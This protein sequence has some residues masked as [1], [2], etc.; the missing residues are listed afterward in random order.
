MS[1]VGLIV[2]MWVGTLDGVGQPHIYASIMYGVKSTHIEGE[3]QSDFR[4]FRS[5]DQHTHAYVCQFPALP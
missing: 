5:P 1:G 3:A 2:A 4:V